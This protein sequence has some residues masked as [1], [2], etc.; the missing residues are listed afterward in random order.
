MKKQNC[1]LSDAEWRIMQSLWRGGSPMSVREI[2]D[3]LADEPAWS[4]HS[5]ISFLK[6]METKGAVRIHEGRPIRYSAA[7][8]RE[9]AVQRETQELLGRVYGGEKLLMIQCAVNASPLSDAERDELI[10]IL[11]GGR[12]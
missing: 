12:K 3:D 10:A 8:D 6:R 4:I 11:K 7:L 5:V 9:A 1:T 2:M